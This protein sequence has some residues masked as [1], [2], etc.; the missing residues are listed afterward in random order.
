MIIIQYRILG[1]A[2]SLFEFMK[3]VLLLHIIKILEDLRAKVET[4]KKLSFPTSKFK[5]SGTIIGHKLVSSN[6]QALI[7]VPW[8]SGE[9]KI[10][11]LKKGR[12][13]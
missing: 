13:K 6:N 1:P 10:S 4:R 3:G 8:F 9:G 11:W 7:K 5:N 12:G 2:Q